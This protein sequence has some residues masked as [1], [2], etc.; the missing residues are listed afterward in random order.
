[1]FFE[2]LKE[3]ILA[4]VY[5]NDA[6]R[7]FHTFFCPPLRMVALSADGQV[8]FDRSDVSSW[9]FVKLPACRYVIETGSKDDYRP[10][11]DT[12]LSLS[13]DLPQTRCAGCQ[14]P[15]GQF[16][17]CLTGRSRGRHPPHS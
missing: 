16:V 5:P 6:T 9:R 1:M 13:P 4:F 2:D 14:H 12:I 7:T 10:Y 3:D 17:V 8:L 15:H 11:M